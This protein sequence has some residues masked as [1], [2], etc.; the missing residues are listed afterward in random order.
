VDDSIAAGCCGREPIMIDD[1]VPSV[2][3]SVE[4]M[5]RVPGRRELIMN[6]SADNASAAG[7]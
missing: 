3:Y 2:E 6:C 5:D 7:Q 4:D 1:V